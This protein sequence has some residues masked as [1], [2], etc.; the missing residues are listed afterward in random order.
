MDAV[1]AVPVDVQCVFEARLD[2]NL[3]GQPAAS[4]TF[5]LPV[6]EHRRV[7]VP[8]GDVVNP[9]EHTPQFVGTKLSTFLDCDVAV[10][11]NVLPI[12]AQALVLDPFYGVASRMSLEVHRLEQLSA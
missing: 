10:Q 11:V 8:D 7:V 6:V 1:E 5:V 2:I 12:Y 3:P 4:W 9:N